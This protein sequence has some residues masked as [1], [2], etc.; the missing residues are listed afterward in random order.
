MAYTH[1]SGFVYAEA[2]QLDILGADGGSLVT[3]QNR[4]LKGGERIACSG[5]RH[6]VRPR[7]DGVSAATSSEMRGGSVWK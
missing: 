4:P 6:E 1:M 5:S 7:I 3:F 2:R